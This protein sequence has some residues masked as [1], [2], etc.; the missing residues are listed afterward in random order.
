[1]FHRYI[2]SLCV[3]AVFIALALFIISSKFANATPAASTGH[4]PLSGMS[5]LGSVTAGPDGNIWFT[6]SFHNKIGRSTPNNLIAWFTILSPTSRPSG[7]TTGTDGNL[8]FTENQ[9]NRIGSITPTGTITEF[10]L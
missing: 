8:W 4:A 9:G 2:H 1:M 5:G 7:I 3:V 6:D 10:P